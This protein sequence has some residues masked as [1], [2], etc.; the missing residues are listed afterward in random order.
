MSKP[1][2]FLKS[3]FQQAL[4]LAILFLGLSD[5]A[6]AESRAGV[7]VEEVGKGSALEKAGLRSG[8]LLFAWERAPDPPANPEGGQGEIRTVFDWLWVKTEQA[9]RGSVRL[10]GERDGMATS[11]DV[12]KGLDWDVRVRPWMAE[13]LLHSYLEGRQRVEAG[14]T[15]RKASPGGTPSSHRR[16]RA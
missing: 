13:D 10:R 9:P 16:S 6:T 15:W 1:R 5:P 12:A 11:F 4:V 7:V 3:R 2:R 8:D 14:V